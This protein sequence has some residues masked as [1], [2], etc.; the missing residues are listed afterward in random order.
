MYK[1]KI[2]VACKYQVTTTVVYILHTSQ[3]IMHLWE[4]DILQ[5]KIPSMNKILGQYHVIK[6]RMWEA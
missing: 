1:E 6:T 4:M 5:K 3:L 2:V